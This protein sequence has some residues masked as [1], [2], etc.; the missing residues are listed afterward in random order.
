MDAVSKETGAELR[1]TWV[2][3]LIAEEIRT[4]QVDVKVAM[5]KQ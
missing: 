2:T 5:I 1:Q 4:R 3:K